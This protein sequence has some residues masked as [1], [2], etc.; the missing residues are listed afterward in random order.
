MTDAAGG[1]VK[2]Q[3]SGPRDQRSGKLDPLLRP[4]RKCRDGAQRVRAESD[5]IDHLQRSLAR[6]GFRCHRSGE[7]HGS[8]Q[9]AALGLGVIADKDVVEDCHR[10]KE[11]HVLKC[12][13]ETTTRSAAS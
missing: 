7:W 2:K 4:E 8:L 6:R 10:A 1:L 5:E 9:P 3:E 13:R 11:G 12:S